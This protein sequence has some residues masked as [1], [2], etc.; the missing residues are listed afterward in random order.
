MANI[1][2]SRQPTSVEDVLGEEERPARLQAGRHKTGGAA[3]SFASNS[4]TTGGRSA[5]RTSSKTHEHQKAGSVKVVAKVR[6]VQ[7]AASLLL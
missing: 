7:Y 4:A 6:V 5:S 3:A 1:L 2:S